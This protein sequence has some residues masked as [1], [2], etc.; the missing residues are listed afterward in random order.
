MSSPIPLEDQFQDVIGKARRGL[1]LTDSQLAQK[2]GI[3][4]EAVEALKDGQPDPAITVA[5]AAA[6]DLD[7]EA[8]LELGRGDWQPAQARVPATFAM[9]NTSYHDMM[10]NAY[11]IW[12]KDGGPAVAFDT[13]GDCKEMLATIDRHRLKVEAILLTH[14]H[15]DHVMKIDDLVNETGAPVYV[16]E[17]EKLADTTRI[18]DGKRFTVGGL[19]ITARLTAGHSPGGTTYVVEGLPSTIAVVGDALFSASMGGVPPEHYANALQANREKIFS[20]PDDTIICPGH[21]PLT[22]VA[23]EKK[24]NAFYAGKL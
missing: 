8:L 16:S 1:R 13:G 2:A 17:F 3:S 11:L 24:H 7:P 12:Q 18:S 4:L 5:V 20:L 19:K 22:T 10:V 15:V 6:L 14:T 9:F 23:E 21:G